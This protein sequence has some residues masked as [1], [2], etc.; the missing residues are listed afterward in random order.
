MKSIVFS[1]AV[2][3]ITGISFQ[4]PYCGNSVWILAGN[5]YENPIAISMRCKY[6]DDSL[7]YRHKRNTCIKSHIREM[8]ILWRFF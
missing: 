3:D 4:N 1:H 5:R 7:I 2:Q 8:S 6:K